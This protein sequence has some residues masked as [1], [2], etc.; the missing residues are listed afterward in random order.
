[1][2]IEMRQARVGVCVAAL[3]ATMCGLAATAH[4]A[5]TYGVPAGWP[6]L[7]AAAFAPSDLGTLAKVTSSRYVKPD[8]SAFA[9]YDREY[10]GAVVRGKRLL[11]LEDDVTLDKTAAQAAQLVATFPLGLVIVAASRAYLTKLL[12][13]KPTYVKVGKAASLGVGDDSVGAVLRLGTKAG[14]IRLIFG[15]VRVRQVVSVISIEGYGRTGVGVADA[16]QLARV[17]VGRVLA[18]MTPQNTAAPA[19]TGTATVGQALTATP[20][21]WLGF[22]ATYT[23]V[24]QR[25]DATGANCA[26]IDGATASSYTVA[27][28]DSGATLAVTVTAT[29]AYGASPPASSPPIAAAG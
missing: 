29:N 24:W 25:C 14:E 1:M 4:A 16:K 9:E 13:F 22:P 15:L 11:D 10:A 6:S 28:T 5:S 8:T 3:A 27:A 23:Y 26:A 18:A 19:V 21:T 7:V 2:M 17:A 20:G 12:G